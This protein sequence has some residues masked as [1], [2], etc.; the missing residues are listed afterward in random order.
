MVATG[1]IGRCRNADYTLSGHIT[2]KISLTAGGID[3]LEEIYRELSAMVKTQHDT[4]S[5]NVP[6]QTAFATGEFARRD[7]APK[8]G[9]DPVTPFQAQPP[10]HPLPTYLTQLMDATIPGLTG[11]EINVGVPEGAAPPPPSLGVVPPVGL[12]VD[13]PPAGFV[14]TGIVSPEPVDGVPPPDQCAKSAPYVPPPMAPILAGKICAYCKGNGAQAEM[15]ELLCGH[16]MHS[17]CV[18][19]YMN[20]MAGQGKKLADVV[21]RECKQ[22]IAYDILN[23]V[24]ERTAEQLLTRNWQLL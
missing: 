11:F 17:V 19:Q 14:A 24:D 13:A 1:T 6:Y 9:S 3:F 22:P 15:K 5:L 7:L 23:S 2:F 8:I 20:E 4:G 10:Y 21:C 12:K 16:A 18:L